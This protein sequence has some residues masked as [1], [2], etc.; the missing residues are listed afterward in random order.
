GF[1]L[2]LRGYNPALDFETLARENGTRRTNLLEPEA[3]LILLKGTA[4]TPHE[5]GKRLGAEG[6]LYGILRDWGAQGLRPAR[7]HTPRIVEL[8]V[9]PPARVLDDPARE[10]QLVVRARFADGSTRDVTHLARYSSTD[11]AVATVDDEG[12]VARRK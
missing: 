2:S 9:T 12:R 3:S 8:L 5:G 11:T 1:R 4:R 10:Q 7:P 6:E